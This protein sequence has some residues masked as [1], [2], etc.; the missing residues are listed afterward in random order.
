VAF[1]TKIPYTITKKGN[2]DRIPIVDNRIQRAD[3]YALSRPLDKV[4]Y[5]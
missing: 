3:T 2:M 4:A 5:T 1:G